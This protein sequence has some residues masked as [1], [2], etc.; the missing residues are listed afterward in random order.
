MSQSNNPFTQ[1]L[2]KLVTDPA[3]QRQMVPGLINVDP[4]QAQ[5][6]EVMKMMESTWDDSTPH[7][8]RQAD[9]V[10]AHDAAESDHGSNIH[11]VAA[12]SHR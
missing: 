10:G 5:L 9:T 2:N 8:N 3:R 7:V 6:G 4:S 11:G 12:G 1:F